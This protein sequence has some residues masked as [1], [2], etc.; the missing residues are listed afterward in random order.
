MLLPLVAGAQAPP[1]DEELPPGMEA[2]DAEDTDYLFGQPE[3]ETPSLPPRVLFSAGG[4]SS[5]RII[6]DLDFNQQRVAPGFIDVFGAIVFGGGEGW[7]HGVGAGVSVNL[8]G[9]GPSGEP[10]VDGGAQWVAGP[11]YLAYIRLGWDFLVAG[12]LGVPVALTGGLSPGVEL[13]PSLTYF[14]TAGFGLYL[15]ATASVW[16]G[17]AST[18]HPVVSGEGGIVLDYEVLP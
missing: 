18:I 7:R 9:D 6:K 15:E 17:A 13:A 12:K 4:G 1:I 5:I 8:S 16:F 11:Y 3:A 10:G 2:D 14:F